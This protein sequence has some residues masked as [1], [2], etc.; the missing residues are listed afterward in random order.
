MKE[1]TLNWLHN[2]Q[3]GG[4]EGER[5]TYREFECPVCPLRPLTSLLGSK[6]SSVVVVV[7]DTVLPEP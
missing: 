1:N 2:T 6:E 4:T 5:K 7:V 3:G